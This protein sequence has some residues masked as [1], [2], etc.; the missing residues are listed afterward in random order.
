VSKINHSP[1]SCVVKKAESLLVWATQII[2]EECKMTKKE[3]R[4]VGID[5][6][7]SWLDIAVYGEEEPKRYQNDKAGI[8]ELL[9]HVTEI[10]AHLIAVEA[11]GGYERQVVETLILRGFQVGVVNPTRVRALA[12]AM[13][14]LAKTDRID[15]KLIAAYAKKI[16]PMPKS[17]QEEPEMKL[18]ALVIRREQ[19]VEMNTAEQSRL[20]TVHESMKDV[21]REHIHWLKSQI[22]LIEIEMKH[23]MDNLPV[24]QAQV[25]RLISIPGVGFITAITVVVNMPELGQLDRQKIAAL[26]GLAP[27]NQDSGKKRGKRR[28]FGG[29]KA[30][31]RVLYM[32]CLSAMTHNPIIE[33]LYKRLIKSGKLFKVAITACMR[34]LLTIMNTMARDQSVWE[35]RL[36]SS[37]S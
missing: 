34:K 10:K 3:L 29:R 9:D 2:Q 17:L 25:D 24:W 23:M 37:G 26:A 30:V 1:N 32:S 4:F 21:I 19:L 11:S 15:A 31:R 13:G 35:P 7:K 22:E 36:L 16:Q 20:G 8:E 12:K 18:K 6:G 5:V 33:K 27:F 28:I 14:L